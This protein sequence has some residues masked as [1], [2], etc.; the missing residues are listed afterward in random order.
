MM[1]DHSRGDP[2][3]MNMMKDKKVPVHHEGDA[4]ASTDSAGCKEHV[5]M[6]HSVGDPKS[7]NMMKYKK[8]PVHKGCKPA[9]S[10]VKSDKPVDHVMMDHSVGDPKSMNMMKDKKVPIHH[11]GAADKP[12]AES[13]P[14]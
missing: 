7:M 12:A 13:A 4:P 5:M 10:T 3:S 14:K 6:D 9:D 2:K 11:D 1:M 8:V